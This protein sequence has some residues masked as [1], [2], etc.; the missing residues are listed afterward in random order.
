MALARSLNRINVKG[1][2]KIQIRELS[3]TA[4][5]TYQDLGYLTSSTLS[6][7]HTM[8]DSVDEIGALVNSQSGARKVTWKTVLKQTSADEIDLLRNSTGKLYEVYYVVTESNTYKKMICL[9]PVRIKSSVVL[10]FASAT[11]RTIEVEMMCLAPKAAYTRGVTAFNIIANDPY[12]L[13]E[14]ATETFNT[15]NTEANAIASAVI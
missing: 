2:G 8:V 1:G 13:V 11:E 14:A 12:V 4:S 5:N 10:N 6:D 3:P 15:T 9:L 7:E